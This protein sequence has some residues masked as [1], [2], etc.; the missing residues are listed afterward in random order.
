MQQL[1]MTFNNYLHNQLE[2][3]IQYK[4]LP[5]GDYHIINEKE[6]KTKDKK[7]AMILTLLSEEK[8]H[9]VFAP[10]PIR[11]L[12]RLHKPNIYIFLQHNGLKYGP[13]GAYWGFILM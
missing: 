11:K 12:I 13:K 3:A 10:T 4:D 1:P 9:Y 6:I 2:Q 8:I 7:G 5:L